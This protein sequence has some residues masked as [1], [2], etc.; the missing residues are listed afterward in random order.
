MTE[1]RITLMINCGDTTCHYNGRR[2]CQWLRVDFAGQRHY[3]QIFG[4]IISSRKSDNNDRIMRHPKCLETE[5]YI[6]WL[7]EEGE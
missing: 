3:C 7:R 2:S 5:A 1:H 6:I 4:E